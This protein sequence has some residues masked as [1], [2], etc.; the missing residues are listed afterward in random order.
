MDCS[1]KQVYENTI[2]SWFF[3]ETKK[4]SIDMCLFFDRLPDLIISG[5]P[6]AVFDKTDSFTKWFQYY[7]FISCGFPKFY[8]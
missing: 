7:C 8:S 1:I 3:S 6:N 2:H 5:S 4:G